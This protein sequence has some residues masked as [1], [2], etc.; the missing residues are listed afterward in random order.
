MKCFFNMVIRLMAVLAAVM[1]VSCAKENPATDY[2]EVNASNLNGNWKLTS[3]DGAPINDGTYFYINFESSGH[4]YKLWENLTS[5]PESY[6]FDKG[7]FRID[8]DE[9]EGA[10]IRGINEV[11]EDWAHLYLIVD[12][13][14]NSMTWIALDDK[15]IVHK[16]VR[17]E[18]IPIDEDKIQ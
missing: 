8:V 13:T 14:E 1:A 2:L 4:E 10:Y 12:L 16:L 18:D 11:L 17:I 3:I 9:E 6:N 15:T 5:I 7:T